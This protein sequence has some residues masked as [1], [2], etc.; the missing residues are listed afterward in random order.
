MILNHHTAATLSPKDWALV[1]AHAGYMLDSLM[2]HASHNIVIEFRTDM[3]GCYTLRIDRGDPKPNVF[4]SGSTPG[5]STKALGA[6]VKSFDEFTDF[7]RLQI[8]PPA[9]TTT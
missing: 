3:D 1:L 9:T 4:Y 7:S 8:A 5:N 6:V 2:C